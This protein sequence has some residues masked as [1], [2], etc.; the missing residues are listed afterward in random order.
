VYFLALATDFDGTIAA[1]GIVTPATLDALRRLK[2]SGRRLILVTGRELPDLI[3]TFPDVALFDCVVAENGGLLYDPATQRERPL[4][5]PPPPLLVERLRD[6]KVAPLSIGRSVIA[7]WEPN[8][9]KVLE[10]VRDLGLERQITFNKG[11]IMILPSGVTKSTGLLA[12]LGM[13]D[14]SAH[15]VVAVG[16]AENDHA[17]LSICG[18]SAAVANALPALKA[19]AD[20]Q[21]TQSHGE[22]VVE[23]IDRVL[24][25]DARIVPSERHGI[26]I[27]TDPAGSVIKLEPAHGSVLIA[28]P[29]RSG[30]TTLAT[31]LTERMVAQ[32]FE[33]CVI[34]PEGDY[35]DLEHTV[36][37]GSPRAAPSVSDVVKLVRD[38][39]INLVINTQALLLA[40][41]RALFSE[42]LLQTAHLRSRTGRPHWLLVDEAHEVFPR[43]YSGVA[44]TDVTALPAG[45]L[46]TI[47]PHALSIDALGLVEV[48][49]AYGPRPLDVFAEFAK[50]VGIAAPVDA[51]Q[52]SD[53][54][55]VYWQ[56]RTDRPPVL[57][58][59]TPPL[60]RH[61]R[62]EGKYAEG[63]VGD[64]HSFYFVS[65]D[66]SQVRKAK[67]LFQFL[68]VAATV[69]DPTWER[70]RRAGDFSAWFRHVIRDEDLAVAAADIEQDRTLDAHASRGRI[71]E[72]IFRTYAAPWRLTM[73]PLL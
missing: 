16:D 66:K 5:A 56:C 59:V 41:R 32:H 19:I 13:L 36:F 1:D 17:F 51:P 30:K 12:A 64:G 50:A 42:I 70:H 23:L 7:T 2:A 14:L 26:A 21:L 18:C 39:T 35:V 54:E 38:S 61:K 60:Q 69:D 31:A 10:A 43:G 25:E 57:V 49:I 24:R 4:A 40:D 22:G 68:E 47:S 55:A 9:G 45:I 15:N 11:A 58:Q 3:G 37:L 28:G 53:G 73:A 63:D 72:V 46:V 29:S 71:K 20:I 48:V 6:M 8:Q 62:H 65:P 34:D 27:G 52:S 44:H 67:N 33:F